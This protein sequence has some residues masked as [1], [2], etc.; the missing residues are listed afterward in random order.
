MKSNIF[1]TA[2]IIGILVMAFTQC[3]S[4]DKKIEDAKEDVMEAN[5]ELEEAR[6]DSAEYVNY[7]D[8]MEVKLRD[9]EQKLEEMK[10]DIQSKGKDVQEK[11]NENLN[12]LKAK[13]ENLKAKI[14]EYQRDASASWDSFKMDFNREMDELGKSISETAEK[15]MKKVEKK[16]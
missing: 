12:T 11:Y 5:R 8:E 4:P 7:R 10:A 9:Y 13:N 6:M 14:R 2:T 3:K 16:K 1:K 15:N